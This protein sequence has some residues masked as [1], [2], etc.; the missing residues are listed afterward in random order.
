VLRGEAPLA[1]S[2]PA[3]LEAVAV[4]VTLDRFDVREPSE[5]QR[6]MPPKSPAEPHAAVDAV[7]FSLVKQSWPAVLDRIKQQTIRM[8]ALA[9]MSHPI[10]FDGSTL[11]LE[12]KSGHQFHADQCGGEEGQK[13]IGGAIHDV[14]GVR[15]R[16]VCTVANHEETAGDAQHEA[17]AAAVAEREAME[18]AG[19][20]PDEEQLH[21]QAIDTLRRSLGATVVDQPE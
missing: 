10:A 7:E 2:P 14:L 18:E 5:P 16:V 21:Q 1:E 17:E 11:H 4:K 12:F 8:H 6:V 15:P 19:D 9:A 3:G 20:L 13:V